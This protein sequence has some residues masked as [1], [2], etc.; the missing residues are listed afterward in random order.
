VIGDGTEFDPT[1]ALFPDICDAIEVRLGALSGY[2]DFG[3]VQMRNA[4]RA[5]LY[6]HVSPTGTIEYE[7][8]PS[9]MW[10]LHPRARFPWESEWDAD[11]NATN[12]P[13][14]GGF[15]VISEEGAPIDESLGIGQLTWD[16]PADY[17]GG[18][19]QGLLPW[20]S[21]VRHEF[22]RRHLPYAKTRGYAKL[23]QTQTFDLE[24]QPPALFEVTEPR[25]PRD[26]GY[27]ILGS[28]GSM[29]RAAMG[30]YLVLQS[31]NPQQV[32]VSAK[33][34]DEW[35]NTMI[36]EWIDVEASGLISVDPSGAYTDRGGRVNAYVAYDGTAPVVNPPGIQFRHRESGRTGSILIDIQ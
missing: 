8:D 22:G 32:F 6:N 2:V 23:R 30:T 5:A 1:D 17:S 20:P 16:D 11:M 15:L 28:P 29:Y 24:N 26:P 34:M 7:I 12:Q 25:R 14:H 3:A 4:P 19:P 36:H 9:G 18:Y 13:A 27:I 33:F 21:G 31:G 10:R 35:Q